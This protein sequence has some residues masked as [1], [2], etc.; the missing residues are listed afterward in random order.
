MA[1]LGLSNYESESDED[2]GLSADRPSRVP[3]TSAPAPDGATA[4]TSYSTLVALGYKGGA[5]LR[6]S[7]RRQEARD[8]DQRRAEL[9]KEGDRLSRVRR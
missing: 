4:S 2:G 7:I 1:F 6:V 9:T 8:E 5:G 3:G